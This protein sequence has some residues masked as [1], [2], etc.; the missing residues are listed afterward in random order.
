MKSRITLLAFI[1]LLPGLSVVCATPAAPANAP[2]NPAM[3]TAIDAEAP[4]CP[5]NGPAAVLAVF[6]SPPHPDPKLTWDS[7]PPC[8]AN[9]VY[10]ATYYYGSPG[11]A[12]CGLTYQYCYISPPPY[13]EGCTTSYYD[14]WYA[15]C[16]CP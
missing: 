14:E 7:F 5:G 9:Q 10:K 2:T 15:Q 12:E 4:S 16:Y 13:H 1:S 6:A 8:G 3:Q 11:G